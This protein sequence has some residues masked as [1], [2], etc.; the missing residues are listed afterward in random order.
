MITLGSRLIQIDINHQMP[1]SWTLTIPMQYLHVQAATYVCP[2]PTSITCF[3]TVHFLPCSRLNG[4]YIGI[5]VIITCTDH[6]YEH[7]CQHTINTCTSHV[8]KYYL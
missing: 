1:N 6:V 2:M 5:I 3:V 8:T 7:S 4:I